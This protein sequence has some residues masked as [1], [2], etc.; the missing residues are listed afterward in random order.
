MN[1]E[2]VL[3]G[4][5]GDSIELAAETDPGKAALVE[6]NVLRAPAKEEI[7]RIALF[8]DAVVTTR[9]TPPQHLAVVMLDGS[10][11]SLLPDVI[12]RPP[13]SATVQRADDGPFRRRIFID[14]SV[15]EVFVN[16]RLCLAQ[17]VAPSRADSTGV[18]LRA[19][20]SD[21]ELRMLDVWQL[22]DLSK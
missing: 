1:E 3:S 2:V 7:T 15:V 14:R 13:E 8:R 21:A 22:K 19:Q 17:R 6:L 20:G 11:A 5:A 4:V 16:G 10:R 9:F 18:S 12:A